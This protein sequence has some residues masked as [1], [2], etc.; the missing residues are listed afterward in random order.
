MPQTEN[1]I[2]V[3]LSAYPTLAGNGPANPNA[4]PGQWDEVS[5]SA[6]VPPAV[7]P[8]RPMDMTH[9]DAAALR[10]TAE[11]TTNGSFLPLAGILRLCTP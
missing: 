7:G 1:D 4:G 9:S 6:S 8:R 10:P 2:F 5:Q 11:R 3:Y